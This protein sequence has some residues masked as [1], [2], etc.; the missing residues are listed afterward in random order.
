MSHR[1]NAV[2]RRIERRPQPRA[3]ANN[4]FPGAKQS[5]FLGC[6]FHALRQKRSNDAALTILENCAP[7]L[8]LGQSSV[9]HVQTAPTYPFAIHP[10][11]G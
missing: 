2:R 1:Y 7:V 3:P 4:P 6:Y 5:D 11:V 9:M 10:V 8:I